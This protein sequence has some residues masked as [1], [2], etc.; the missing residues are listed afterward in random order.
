MPTAEFV[1]EPNRVR[2]DGAVDVDAVALSLAVRQEDVTI[3]ARTSTLSDEE[4]RLSYDRLDAVRT[5]REATYTLVFETT[6][7]E[8]I[9]T[10]VS[11]DRA[12]V[13]EAVDY[14]RRRINGEPPSTAGSADGSSGESE[15]GTSPSAERTDI[16]E[17]AADGQGESETV[18]D[19]TADDLDEWSWGETP[20]R[21]E[22]RAGPGESFTCPECEATSVVPETVPQNRQRV[23][24]P[25]CGDDIGH[26]PNGETVVVIPE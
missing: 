26:T 1:F 3:E 24:C 2:A 6:A 22:Q 8:Y 9:V 19:G 25:S 10:N 12:T 20:D 23:T 5:R 18:S 16:P 21:S 11:P 15:R 7:T 13:R 4:L 14:V 17:T